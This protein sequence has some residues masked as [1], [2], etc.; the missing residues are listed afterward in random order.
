MTIAL[1]DFDGTITTKDSLAEFLCFAIGKR[2]YYQGLFVLAPILLLYKLKLIPN[3]LAKEKM[4]SYF[5][6][7]Y[8]KEHFNTI[9]LKFSTNEISKIIRPLA[10]EKINW[11]KTQG[12]KV[13]IVSA[14]IESWLKDWCE[15]Y[16]VELIATRL[17]IKNDELTGRFETKNC[18]GPEKVSRLKSKY[19]LDTFSSIYVYGD[20]RGDK[21]LLE[22]ADYS[23]YKPFRS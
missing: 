8:S 16:E 7:G 12:H 1:F 22:L 11:H 4:L 6:K 20:S 21:E 5:F 15:Q 18:Y 23:F 10:L 2:K 19:S 9:A 17:E 3:Y 14:S 13:V